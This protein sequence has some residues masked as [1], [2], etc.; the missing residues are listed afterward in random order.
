MSSL[1][2]GRRALV[3]MT[4]VGVAAV[5][6]GSGWF[7]LGNHGRPWPASASRAAVSP[8]TAPSP[9]APVSA[10][11]TA[12]PQ[13][14]IEPAKLVI[15]RFGVQAP[16]ENKGIDS[17]NTMEAP[18]RPSDV[19]WYPF[20]ARPGS[21]GNA[22]FAGHRDFAGF[23]PAI[24]WHL[25]DMAAGDEI[26]VVGIDEKSLRYRVTQTWNYDLASIPMASVLAQGNGDQITL[27]TCSGSYT[28]STGYDKRF[29]VR[30][31]R[32]G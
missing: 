31:D 15:A 9:A 10:P 1:L 11:A 8:H 13:T 29:V 23:G 19:A 32:I 14:P 30:A 26:V 20:T 22:V 2:R 21:G 12:T 7:L 16:I 6:A 5:L 3:A 28:R 4:A 18:D 24:F 27:I 25:G 17:H